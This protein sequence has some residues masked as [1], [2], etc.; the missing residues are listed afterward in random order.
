QAQHAIAEADSG[1]DA[2]AAARVVL[3]ALAVARAGIVSMREALAR[4]P[5]GCHPLIFYQRVRPFLSGWKANPTLP[6]GVVYEGV[7]S[8]KR[9]YYGGSAAQST[10]FPALDAALEVS[11]SAH[12][13]NAFL[14]EMRDYMPPGHRRLLEHLAD[15]AC[16]SIRRFV[17][18]F[19]R[20]ISQALPS[21]NGGD[22][23]GTEA[24]TPD[25]TV[26]NIRETTPGN[27]CRGGDT[28]A[29]APL[30]EA[31]NSCL[32]A[33]S[34]FRSTHLGIVGSYILQQQKKD[35]K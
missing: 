4:M 7:S 34:D 35:Q 21:K 6:D 2:S 31:Y 29:A 25:E 16:P 8:K 32:G 19:A 14:L 5:V 24:D 3:E 1:S 12:S 20:R 22:V 18:D 23:A 33:L 15:P 26:E 13:S 11:H 9:Q 10:L 17:Q 27:G 28:T 30:R